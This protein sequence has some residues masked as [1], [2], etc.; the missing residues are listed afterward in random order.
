L[1]EIVLYCEERSEKGAGRDEI[2]KIQRVQ[3]VKW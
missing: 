1:T 3:G 2:L